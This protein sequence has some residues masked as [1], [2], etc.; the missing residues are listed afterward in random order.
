MNTLD[1]FY[2][3]GAWVNPIS[4]STMPLMNPAT[5][6]Q[7]GTLSLGNVADVNAAVALFVKRQPA[8]FVVDDVSIVESHGALVDRRQ[9]TVGP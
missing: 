9:V 6:T 5:N 2:I 8:E 3:N 4:T 7:I 1:K